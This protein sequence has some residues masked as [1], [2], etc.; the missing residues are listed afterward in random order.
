[1]NLQYHW[2]IFYYFYCSGF[3]VQLYE[4]D[5]FDRI[6]QIKCGIGVFPKWIRNSANSVNLI[7]HRTMNRSQFKD[8]VFHLCIVGVVVASWSLEQEVAEWQLRALIDLLI[9][10]ICDHFTCIETLWKLWNEA[11]NDPM[12]MFFPDTP[13]FCDHLW[14]CVELFSETIHIRWRWSIWKFPVTVHSLY[15][16]MVMTNIFITEFSEFSENI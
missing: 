12:E 14:S 15:L 5:E 7:N 4:L 16:V 13:S 2:Q 1:M 11:R 9:T 3:L 8:P 6:T 10:S